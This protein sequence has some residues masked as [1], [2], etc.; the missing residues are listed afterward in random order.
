[1]D[2]AVRSLCGALSVAVEDLMAHTLQAPEEGTLPFPISSYKMIPR[3]PRR[4]GWSPAMKQGLKD[5]IAQGDI[6]HNHSLWI[7]PNVYA[8]RVARQ[9]CGILINAPHGGFYLDS[10]RIL[11]DKSASRTSWGSGSARDNLDC[12]HVTALS[13]LEDLRALGHSQPVAVVSNGVDI[14]PRR[15]AE[16]SW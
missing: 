6:V 13:E 9:R 1:M 16:G 7:M 10:S 8:G 4:L 14:P 3:S 2:V 5:A 12:F 11:H 15:P